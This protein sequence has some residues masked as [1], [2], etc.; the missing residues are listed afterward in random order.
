MKRLT[1]LMI[2]MTIAFSLHSISVEKFGENQTGRVKQTLGKF[3]GVIVKDSLGNPLSEIPVKFES[4]SKESCIKDSMIYT[5]SD[6]IASTSA[7][8]GKKMGDYSFS[9]SV[10][11][12]DNNLI[13]ENFSFTAFDYKNILFFIFGGLGMFL[14]GIMKVS[15]SLRYLAGNKLKNFLEL[16]IKNRIIGVFVGLGI[17]AVLQS[18]S[19]TTVMTLGFINAGLL[20]LKQAI[21]IIFGANIGTTMTAQIMAFQIGEVALPF[22]ALGAGLIIFS[23]KTRTI[24]IGNVIFGFGLLFYGLNIMTDIVKPLSSSVFVKDFFMNFSHHPLLAIFAGTVITLIIQSSS[25]TVGVTIALGISGLID[26]PAAMGLVLG[27]NIGTTITAVLASFGSNANARR[28]ALVHVLFNVIGA[29]YMF[30]ILNFAT[31][32]ITSIVQSF[33]GNDIARQIANFHSLFNIVNTIIFLPFVVPLEKLVK[34]IIPNREESSFKITKYISQNITDRE[35][36]I[37]QMKLEL[38]RMMQNT[39]AAV[40]LSVKALVKADMVAADETLKL[41]DESDMFQVEITDYIVKLSK[42]ELDDEQASYIPVLIHVVNDFEKVGDYAKNIAQVAK[43]KFDNTIM[44]SNEQIDHI[45]QMEKTIMLMYENLL[46]AFENTDLKKARE[47]TSLET[48]LND[49]EDKFKKY[50]I[51]GLS[52]GHSV[53]SAIITMDILMNLEK[54][55]DRLLNVAQAV[56]GKLSE[57]EKTLYSEFLF[58]NTVEEEM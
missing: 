25:A 53:K 38:G 51:K 37:N 49:M 33:S 8:L 44:L 21:G 26:L 9:A 4:L 47:V 35:L 28:A 45:Y 16:V 46:I 54:I 32:T 3:F 23:K 57:D 5:N 58:K 40:N 30:L 29:A 2:L 1:I 43:N 52:E 14:F 48:Q 55:G 36:A 42:Q 15:D 18:S 20:T 50:K 13:T 11:I 39:K 56:M 22:I 19:C 6:G 12:A 24:Y 17:T 7:I 31:N 41:E 10:I 34:W 27:D